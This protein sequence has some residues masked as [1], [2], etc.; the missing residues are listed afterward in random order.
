[1]VKVV[2]AGGLLSNKRWAYPFAIVALLALA[3]Y[4]VYR[5]THT[6]SPLLPVLSAIDAGIAWL[7]WREARVRGPMAR[8]RR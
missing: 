6:H 8:H 3:G 1:V 2:L 5:F 7:V 4:Q